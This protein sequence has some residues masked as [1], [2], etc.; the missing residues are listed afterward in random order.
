LTAKRGSVSAPPAALVSVGDE[1]LL[2]ETVDTNG[3][4]LGRRLSDLG[5]LVIRR[6]VV[7]DSRREIQEGVGSALARAEVVLVTGG[8]GP[9]PD[10]LTLP[11][12]SDLLGLPLE[13]DSLILARLKERFR[14]RGL[15]DLPKQAEAM[16]RVPKGSRILAN[17]RGSAPGLAVE[18]GQGR[19]CI[20]LPGVPAEMRGIFEDEVGPLLRERFSPRLEPVRLR[21]IHTTGIPESLLA[22]EVARL[23]LPADG[24]V[25]VAFLPDLRGVRIRLTARG[26]PGDYRVE[27]ALGRFEEILEPVLAPYR[28]H[29]RSGDLAEALGQ[30]LLHTGRTLAT[31]ESCTGGLIAKR[32]TDHPGSSRYFL[33]SVVAYADAAKTE[34]LG[35]GERLLKEKGAVSREVAE[36]MASGVAS[37]FGATAGIAVTGVAGPGGGTE[38]K[39]VGTVWLA[40]SVGDDVFS[41]REL[42]TGDRD[43]V[44]E[45]GAQTAMA[46]LLNELERVGP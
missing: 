21:L 36:A 16:A 5:F 40:V 29:S 35:V 19:L 42:F 17:V 31:A 15:E 2:G 46:F 20:L 1:L 37:R 44:R 30:A 39:P 26:V 12:V 11:A 45:R 7:G 27:E 32:M 33:G 38:D 23:G 9:T 34:L 13:T 24:P 6:W 10:D 22:G 41:R 18:A 8:L 4:W 3:S 28:Y 25:S 43:D 14:A